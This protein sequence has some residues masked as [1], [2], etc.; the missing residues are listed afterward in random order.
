MNR[1]ELNRSDFFVYCRGKLEILYL[2][3][4]DEKKRL[5]KSTQAEKGGGIKANR[6]EDFFDF[7][8]LRFM[9]PPIPAK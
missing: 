5:L 9:R 7:P 3:I 4:Y 8:I 6:R 2:C 1:S